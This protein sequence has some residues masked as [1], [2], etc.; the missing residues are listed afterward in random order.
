ML[1][2]K[3]VVKSSYALHQKQIAERVFVSEEQ[4]HS[5]DWLIPSSEKRDTAPYRTRVAL[6]VGYN[7][8]ALD[9]LLQWSSRLRYCSII[10][11]VFAVGFKLL[12]MGYS[13][14][15]RVTLYR[16]DNNTFGDFFVAA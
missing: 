2:G 7:A 14:S 1:I 3:G 9:L 5:R 16:T 11:P 6:I 4:S 8:L 15:E 12:L 13:A 10:P